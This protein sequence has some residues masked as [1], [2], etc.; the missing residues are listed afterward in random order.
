[1]IKPFMAHRTSV[2]FLVTMNLNMAGQSRVIHETFVAYI[3]LQR[4]RGFI[5][6]TENVPLESLMSVK[7]FAT[8]VTLEWSFPQK[9]VLGCPMLSCMMYKH[10][11]VGELHLANR[12]SKDHLYKVRSRSIHDSLIVSD[13]ILLHPL[14]IN[15]LC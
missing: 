10:F 11:G 3:T 12:T 13:G 8:L 15:I 2:I 6:M 5:P 14:H 1:M 9:L 4:L 7:S